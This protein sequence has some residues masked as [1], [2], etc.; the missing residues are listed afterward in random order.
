MEKPT[1]DQYAVKAAKEWIDRKLDEAGRE[2]FVELSQSYT[3]TSTNT[4]WGRVHT[5]TLNCVF[6]NVSDLGSGRWTT[7]PLGFKDHMQ[8]DMWTD[9]IADGEG[10]YETWALRFCGNRLGLFIDEFDW[11]AELACTAKGKHKGNP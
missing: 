4:V 11:F 8:K 7:D 1:L 9:T 3:C 10:G 2:H 5:F 6:R